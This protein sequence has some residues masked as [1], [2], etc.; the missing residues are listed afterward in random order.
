MTGPSLTT[1]ITLQSR[2]LN[3]PPVL[4]KY[5]KSK[6]IQRNTTS[7]K[8]IK[9]NSKKYKETYSKKSSFR[10]DIDASEY[11]PHAGQIKRKPINDK[12]FYDKYL[13][14]ERN[15]MHLTVHYYE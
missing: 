1:E 3:T 10:G 14:M 11:S 15:A 12:Y 8:E 5:E 2:H 4:V 9:L 6:E 13:C 7:E